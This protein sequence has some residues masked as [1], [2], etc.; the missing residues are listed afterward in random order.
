MDATCLEEAAVSD[1]ER[2][3][4]TWKHTDLSHGEPAEMT[5]SGDRCA[6]RFGGR[7]TW[8]GTFRLE[9]TG[10]GGRIDVDLDGDASRPCLGIYRLLSDEE[11]MIRIESPQVHSRPPDFET[12]APGLKRRA[13]PWKRVVPASE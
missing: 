8:S 12:V 2:L 5:I 6:M 9:A 7:T 11:L 3:Q 4:G 10:G 1:Y 13:Y